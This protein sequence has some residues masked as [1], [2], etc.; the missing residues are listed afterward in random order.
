MWLKISVFIIFCFNEK[1][2]FSKV[3]KLYPTC[4]YAYTKMNNAE[5]QKVSIKKKNT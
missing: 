1:I 3:I 4:N 5:D 2:N